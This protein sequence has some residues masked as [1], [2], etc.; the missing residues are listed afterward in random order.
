VGVRVFVAVGVGVEVF[1]IV[2]VGVEVFVTVGVGVG[3]LVASTTGGSSTSGIRVF[4]G[5]GFAFALLKSVETHPDDRKTAKISSITMRNT[6]LFIL[7][8]CCSK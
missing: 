5:I 8:D 1:V 3:L 7:M 2:E 4:V 6:P